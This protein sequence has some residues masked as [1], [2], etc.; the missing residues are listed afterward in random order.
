[1][2][3]LLGL[4]GNILLWIQEYIRNDFLTPFFVFITKL[5]DVGM[6]WIVLTL[7]LMCNKKTRKTCVISAVALLLSLLFC[8]VLL[9]NL[10][11]RVRPYEV[12]DTLTI[13]VERQKDFSFP[14]GH[15]SA[16]F[17]AGIVF[18]KNLPR[19]FGVPAVILA[20]LISFSRLY[21]GVH[22]PTDVICSIV[23]G[24][25]LAFLSEQLCRKILR[26]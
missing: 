5:G 26:R 13:L 1:M 12:I 10:V 23:F 7:I 9:K 24:V 19:K 22:Y 17:A 14:S 2:E 20:C 25:V 18:L 15:T 8:N 6:I 21:I 4:D 3:V 16:S 11:Q